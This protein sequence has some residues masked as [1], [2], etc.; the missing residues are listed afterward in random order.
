MADVAYTFHFPV[1]ELWGMQ[2]EELL[3]WHEQLRRIYA[4]DQHDY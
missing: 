4:Q 3:M 1:S 2:F